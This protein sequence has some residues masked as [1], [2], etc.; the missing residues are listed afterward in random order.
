M[1][2]HLSK[3][4]KHL[5]LSQIL[6]FISIVLCNAAEVIVL[7]QGNDIMTPMCTAAVLLCI[8]T[9]LCSSILELTGLYL[10]G[11]EDSRFHLLLAASVICSAFQIFC[12]RV[13]FGVSV[14][15]VITVLQLFLDICA[16]T[17]IGDVLR[18]HGDLLLAAKGHRLMKIYCVMSVLVVLV[19]NLSEMSDA[20]ACAAIVTVCLLAAVSLYYVIS[21]TRFLCASA[22][23]LC[24]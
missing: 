1:T 15:A 11:K 24:H 16:L 20:E 2:S 10:C 21:Y 13:L 19:M 18:Q 22:H 17:L 5:F 6:A 8:V 12:D 7:H 3:G 14:G 23:A 9:G 4:I